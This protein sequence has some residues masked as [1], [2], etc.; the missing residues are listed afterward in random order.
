MAKETLYLKLDRNVEIR[1]E[2]VRIGDLG[3][4]CCRDE[5]LLKR[6]RALQVTRMG[7]E[8]GGRKVISVM[9]LIELLQRDCPG[10]EV[11]NIGETEVIVRR[12]G[13]DGGGG[14]RQT[15]KA[16]FVSLIC[17]FGAGFTIMAFHNDI[18]IRPVFDRIQEMVTGQIPE[19]V[20]A[21]ETGYAAGLAVGIAVF[22]NHIGGWRITK[23]PTPIEVEM[24]IYEDQVSDALVETADRE[25]KT[26]DAGETRRPRRKG[27]DAK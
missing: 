16:C 8:D 25:G 9:K 12:A 5:T 1:G 19:G 27:E 11:A 14:L 23:D 4:L 2:D 10:L 24:R 15:L 6:I 26:V 17:F 3:T 20:T 13:A 7:P 21:L 22:F 18:G